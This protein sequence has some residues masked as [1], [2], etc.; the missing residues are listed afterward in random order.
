MLGIGYSELFIIAFAIILF[1]K[2]EDIPKVFRF[3]GKIAGKARAAYNEALSIKDQIVNEI[4]S[5]ADFTDGNKDPAAP[6]DTSSKPDD[7]A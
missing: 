3:L 5:A 6:A 7:H 4:D 1:V 2:P